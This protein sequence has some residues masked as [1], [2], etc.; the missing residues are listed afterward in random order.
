MSATSMEITSDQLGGYGIPQYGSKQGV[1]D[2]P[3]ATVYGSQRGTDAD[4]RYGMSMPL[5]SI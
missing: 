3:R 1:D 5:I 4:D 2:R